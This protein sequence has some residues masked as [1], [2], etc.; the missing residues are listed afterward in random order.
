MMVEMDSGPETLC[1]ITWPTSQKK[2]IFYFLGFITKTFVSL[3]YSGETL[4]STTML[5]WFIILISHKL[6]T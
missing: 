3:S 2:G 6:F 4:S 5:F 1:R